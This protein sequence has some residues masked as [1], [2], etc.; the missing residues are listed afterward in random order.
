[1]NRLH[2][3][4]QGHTGWNMTTKRILWFSSIILL[5]LHAV[6]FAY[7]TEPRL[8]RVA[9]FNYYPAIFKDSDGQIKGFYVEALSD[10]AK[11]ENLKIEYI[12][13]AW[14]EGLERLISGK[15]DVLTSVAYTQ[16]YA[17]YMDY[18]KTPLFTA[19]GELYARFDSHIDG[20]GAIQGKKVAIVK[21]DYNG[22]KFIELAKQ[23]N[24]NCTFIEKGGFERVFKAIAAGEADAGVV[25]N[26]FG[27]A[28]HKTYNLRST[29]VVFNP[30]E[31]YFSVA[32]GKKQELLNLLNTYL[33]IWLHD[34]NSAYVQARHKWMHPLQSPVQVVPEWLK[35]TTA[36]LGVMAV[37]ALAFIYLLR[38]QVQQKT[39]MIRQR[40]IGLQKSNEMITLLLNSTA[41]AICGIDQHG[42]CIFCNN[43]CLRML[44]Y[45]QA[46]QLIGKN[47]YELTHHTCTGD[48]GIS[49]N[50]NSTLQH[51]KSGV[52]IHIDDEVLC[53]LDGSSFHAEYW[54]H[55]IIQDGVEVGS[56][57]TFLDVTSRRQ[58]EA[59]LRESEEQHRSI[60][61]NNHSVMLIVDP[62]SKAIVDANPAA[63][64]YYGWTRQQLQQMRITDINTLHPD[65]IASRLE[66]AQQQ[67]L[68]HFHF[69]HRLANNSIRDVEVFSSPIQSGGTTLLFLIIH[70][71]TERK[72]LEDALFFLLKSGSTF[73][74]TDFFKALVQYLAQTLEM[75]Y[76]SIDRLLEDKTQTIA[77]YQDGVC[78]DT[79][80]YAP[81][82][83]SSHEILKRSTYRLE[84]G[85]RHLFPEDTILQ[86]LKAEHLIGTTLWGL[87]GKPIGLITL[88][89]RTP[90]M[91]N[92]FIE[93]IL[94]M[95]SIRAAAE[96]ERRLAE[97]VL[98]ENEERYRTL[99][100]HA[101]LA[102]MVNQNN[103]IVLVN[104]ACLHLFGATSEAQLLGKSPFEL[105]HP[106]CHSIIQ[107]RIQQLMTKSEYVPMLEET[108]V[109]LDGS[110]VDV[111]VSAATFQCKGERAIHVVLQ[112]ISDRKNAER[113]RQQLEAQLHHA[114]RMEAIGTFAGGIAHDFNNMLT[115][116]IGYAYTG[117]KSLTPD[118]PQHVH[119][120]D[121]VE[122]ANRA[123]SLT[124]DLLLFSRKHVS[125]RKTIELNHSISKTKSFLQRIIGDHIQLETR[126][127]KNQ[128]MVDVD[129]QQLDQVLMNLCT[130]ARDAMP[131]GGTITIT[132]TV[133][134]MTAAEAAGYGLANAGKYA[135]I[136]VADTGKGIAPEH[137]SKIFDPFFTT[138]AT[139]KG[140]G[141]GLAIVYGIVSNH[142]GCITITDNFPHGTVF[143]IH[144]PCSEGRASVTDQQEPDELLLRGNETILIAD[145]SERILKMASQ[146]LTEFGY[147]VLTAVDGEDAVRLFNKNDKQIRLLLF[148]LA[149]PRLG[150]FEAYQQI[151]Q[152]NPGIPVIFTTG[153]APQIAQDKLTQDQLDQ[154]INKPYQIVKLLMRIRAA[155]DGEENAL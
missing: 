146:I 43:A 60:F 140:T 9:A 91:N 39:A 68:H 2:R 151:K 99:I 46:E 15:V 72:R 86:N 6:P 10:L 35:K 37:T 155:L 51:L 30:F 63:I 141:L 142:D 144:L 21:G 40:E 12:Y 148:D 24:I 128:I 22:Q 96:L 75:D 135:A 56:V 47:I 42:N 48:T 136:S 145:D 153:Y 52:Q 5:L 133:V 95:V 82:G 89:G 131:G 61:E 45:E 69:K 129:T 44:G 124:R 13:G 27:L 4:D 53:R 23:F 126:S 62:K 34:K 134:G 143:T 20:I 109:R 94:H 152:T 84:H 120:Q 16:E 18:T 132:T 8:V 28:K 154:I 19:W 80:Q 74:S 67:N 113:V 32:K 105:F 41:E 55:P 127:C 49:K 77:V 71:I 130:N 66:T 73:S 58:I 38:R 1:M 137:Q 7:A 107:D 85:A 111:E 64:T 114:Q 104:K 59:K 102:V 97:E 101:P 76:V 93:P 147:H 150:G 100:E 79:P 11:R 125:C 50:D 108:I 54:S 88:I 110:T 117:Q 119:F 116:V 115:A 122:T 33:H 36:A 90:L 112:N 3:K 65:Q 14:H 123:S 118:A 25:N 87:E 78:D 26:T 31:V 149:M 121:I 57:I 106:N 92:S 98:L 138:K 83:A 103:Q 29:G 70:D 81:L 17:A 139:G